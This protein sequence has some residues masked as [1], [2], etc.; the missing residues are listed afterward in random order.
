M[1]PKSGCSA[2][3]VARG[4]DCKLVSYRP[5]AHDFRADAAP[6]HAAYHKQ[7]RLFSG[8]RVR[9]PYD[10]VAA[11]NVSPRA[12]NNV[13]M[14]VLSMRGGG[15]GDREATLCVPRDVRH[16]LLVRVLPAREGRVVLD[17]VPEEDRLSLRVA[18][19]DDLQS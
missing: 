13:S 1:A 2:F 15:R 5:L 12:A 17:E 6:A 4:Y 9:T 3:A 14:N 11:N 7:N 19:A 18:L 16:E 8:E 10:A